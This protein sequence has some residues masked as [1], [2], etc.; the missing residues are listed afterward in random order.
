MPLFFGDLHAKCPHSFSL[1]ARHPGVGRHRGDVLRTRAVREARD[2]AA[3][4]AVQAHERVRSL[5]RLEAARPIYARILGQ[6]C[7]LA[8]STKQKT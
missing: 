7:H 2:A 1:L 3:A 6:P 4:V 8:V 5:C